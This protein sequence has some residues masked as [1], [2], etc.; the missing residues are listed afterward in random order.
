MGSVITPPPGSGACAA[1]V[2]S[3]FVVVQVRVRLFA[4][5]RERAGWSERDLDGVDR[6]GDVWGALELGRSRR[7]SSTP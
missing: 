4:G 3:T 2:V 6:V 5:L 7:V 1:I